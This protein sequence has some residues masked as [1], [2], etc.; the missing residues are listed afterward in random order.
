MTIGS[1]HWREGIQSKTKNI[2]SVFRVSGLWYL[3]FTTI[4]RLL[5]LFKYSGIALSEEI[6]IG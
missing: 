2:S 3:S 1:K 6:R 4:D 5:E